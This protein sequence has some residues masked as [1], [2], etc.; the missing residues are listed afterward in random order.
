MARPLREELFF[1]ASL[2]IELSSYF[3][4]DGRGLEEGG[5][6]GPLG[7]DGGRRQADGHLASLK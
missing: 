6:P 3:T 5:G 2:I 7:H 1:A 4:S